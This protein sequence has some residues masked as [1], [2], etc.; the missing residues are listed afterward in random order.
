MRLHV[1][2]SVNELI[3]NKNPATIG[4]KFYVHNFCTLSLDKNGAA[5]SLHDRN[6]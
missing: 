3:I 4:V 2:A 6:C 5:C 1:S